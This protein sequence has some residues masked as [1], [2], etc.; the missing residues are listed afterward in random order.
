MTIGAGPSDGV[1]RCHRPP[2]R[3]GCP[4]PPWAASGDCRPRRR[5]RPRRPSSRRPSRRLR[6]RLGGRAGTWRRSDETRARWR[7]ALG[8]TLGRSNRE[9]ELSGGHGIRREL[10]CGHRPVRQRRGPH[11]PAAE[12]GGVH[13]ARRDLAPLTAPSRSAR[14]VTA[15]V[16]SFVEVTARARSCLGPTL[17]RGKVSAYD[18]PPSAT[19]SAHTATAIAG[20]GS[21]TL[22]PDIGH[23]FRERDARATIGPSFSWSRGDCRSRRRRGHQPRRSSRDIRTADMAA[24]NGSPRHVSGV[25]SRCSLTLSR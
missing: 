5:S 20:E 7:A 3:S 2:T 24:V 13:A 19:N 14:T 22:L 11:R 1:R 15:P 21:G 4:S 16:P 23:S 10:G 8:R 9:A 17:S 12:V 6:R 25:S 18:A